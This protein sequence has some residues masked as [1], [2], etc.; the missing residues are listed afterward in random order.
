[1]RLRLANWLAIGIGV[2]VVVLA[3]IFRLDSKRR[4]NVCRLVVEI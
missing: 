4:M 2:A 1:M 3:I